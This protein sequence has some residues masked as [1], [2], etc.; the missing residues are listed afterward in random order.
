MRAAKNRSFCEKWIYANG[1]WKTKQRG[2]VCSIYSQQMNASTDKTLAIVAVERP[3]LSG[4]ICQNYDYYFARKEKVFCFASECSTA[5]VDATPCSRTIY[6]MGSQDIEKPEKRMCFHY[7]WCSARVQLI[8]G[9]RFEIIRNGEKR[10]KEML[11]Q[12]A[13]LI[14]IIK[15]KARVV[16]AL[17][18]SIR[19]GILRFVFH[20]PLST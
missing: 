6:L 11:C 14:Y 10:R 7:L 5:V 8:I 15:F 18:I 20:K 12:I 19:Y 13:S 16:A 3:R 2:T 1:K 9:I 4:Q 17:M